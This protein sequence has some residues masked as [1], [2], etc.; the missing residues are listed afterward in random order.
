[1]AW[2]SLEQRSRL[3]MPD[4]HARIL[5]AAGDEVVVYTSEAAAQDVLDLLLPAELAGKTP[6]I[7]I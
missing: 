4:V 2:Q 1:M 5:G 6:L 3:A 7:Q